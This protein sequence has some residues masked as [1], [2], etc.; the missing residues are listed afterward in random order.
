LHFGSTPPVSYGR[1]LEEEPKKC[2][3]EEKEDGDW[4][5]KEVNTFK[6]VLMTIMFAEC[7]IGL[8]P[9]YCKKCME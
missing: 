9:A 2:S 4:T 6:I 5:K 7:Y 1:V 3:L 8:L